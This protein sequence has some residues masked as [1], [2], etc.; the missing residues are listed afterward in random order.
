MRKIPI[1]SNLS[2][3]LQN[4]PL[5]AVWREHQAAPPGI[6]AEPASSPGITAEPASSPGITTEPSSTPD[7]DDPDDP[8][9]NDD[10]D[11]DP[12]TPGG[13]DGDDDDDDDDDDS[14]PGKLVMPT[15]PNITSACGG[16]KRVKIRWDRLSDVTGYKVYMSTK[17]SS[18]FKCVVTL[19]GSSKVSY[20]KTGLKQNKTYYFKVSSYLE[21]DDFSPDH[22][23]YTF[24]STYSNTVSAKTCSVSAT[25]QTPSLFATT[26]K[27]KKSAAYKKYKA[28]RKYA[29]YSKSFA[30][31][32]MKHTNAGGFSSTK[33]IPQGMCQ[34]GGYIL[35]SA[36][37]S[38]KK[39][40]S[41]IYVLNRSS[42]S[43]ITTIV[44]PS[45]A[46]VQ[47]MA[48]DGT[49][50]WISKDSTVAY[51]P[52]SVLNTASISG[53][54]YYILP[55]YTASFEVKTKVGVM[56]YYKNTL[57]IGKAGCA[58]SSK[59]YGYTLS[60]VNKKYQ[61]TK[62]YSMTIP[63]RTQGI[64]F[65]NK[66]YLYVTRSAKTNP[67]ASGYISC[68][69]TFKPAFS[70]PTKTGGIKKGTLKNKLKLP[71]RVEGVTLYG[72]YLY[73]LYSSCKYPKSKYPV[74]RV[75]AFKL[76]KLR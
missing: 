51:F 64:A 58:H 25:S 41:V 46:K 61:V 32:G 13:I 49:N 74:D 26:S 68:I 27:F 21:S 59:M 48:Y 4:Q 29:V 70:K 57:W 28:L 34:A 75:I 54:S 16:Y 66:G 45:R 22:V 24:Q 62:K 55:Q 2:F 53:N 3:I 35:I 18:G 1:R 23:L 39:N 7:T 38:S 5:A 8:D 42:H 11:S 56:T 20:L 31:P 71:P 60:T 36:Y 72:K 6:T 30:I 37:D 9:D 14:A 43:Y 40:D 63:S 65:D 50:I 12:A 15:T 17:K 47:S 73:T 67:K 10:D 19:R 76:K 52:Y 44:L 33:M 69:Q